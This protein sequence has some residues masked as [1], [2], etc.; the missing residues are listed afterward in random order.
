MREH[1]GVA[2]QGLGTLTQLGLMSQM[3]ARRVKPSYYLPF[4]IEASA[5]II[6]F[7]KYVVA[8]YV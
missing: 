1:S 2:Q 8:R 5:T 4:Q 3:Y 6:Y 7:N